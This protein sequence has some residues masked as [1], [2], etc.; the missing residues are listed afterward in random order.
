MLKLVLIL[1]AS[2]SAGFASAFETFDGECSIKLD[3]QVVFQGPVLYTAT[4]NNIIV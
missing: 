2:L 4:Q 1:I 3:D